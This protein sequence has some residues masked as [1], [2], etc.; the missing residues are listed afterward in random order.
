MNRERLQAAFL[1]LIDTYVDEEALKQSLL[2]LLER[3]PVPAKGI[4]AGLQP[5]M[6]SI[7]P[8]DV[9]VL[10]EIVHYYV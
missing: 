5:L 9:E 10:Q 4:L 8:A 6:R 2:P 7:T 1:H 3:E